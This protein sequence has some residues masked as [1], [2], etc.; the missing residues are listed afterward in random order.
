MVDVT[1][2]FSQADLQ[3]FR[4]QMDRIIRELG[5]T[6]EAAVNIGTIAL[7]KS[8]RSS[9]KRGKK[10]RKVIE[11]KL[12]SINIRTGESTTIKNDHRFLVE[13]WRKGKKTLVPVLADSLE[14]AKKSKR[15][16]IKFSGLGQATMGWSMQRLFN[17]GAPKVNF[18]Q[19]NGIVE[20]TRRGKGNDYTITIQNNANYIPFRTKGKTAVSTA[21]VRAAAAMRG[22]TEQ[23]LK[24][25]F[26]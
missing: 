3:A 5:K 6:P 9:I 25:T 15:A 10:V 11:D 20:T 22:R 24:G 12:T 18:R 23:R 7:I 8:L 2:K 1:V 21:M 26:K 14:A 4:N 19:P 13:V 16:Q 17:N